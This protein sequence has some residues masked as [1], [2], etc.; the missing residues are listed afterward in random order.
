MRLLWFGLLVWPAAG[1]PAF[2][3]AVLLSEET[4]QSL[5][6]HESDLLSLMDQASQARDA[7]Q[8]ARHLQVISESLTGVFL[9][10]MSKEVTDRFL[11]HMKT[12]VDALQ[13]SIPDRLAASQKHLDHVLSLFYKCDAERVTKLAFADRHEN[14]TARKARSHILCR[15]E[16]AT[17]KLAADTCEKANAELSRSLQEDPTCQNWPA[18]K[19][20]T[21][22]SAACKEPTEKETYEEYLERMRSEFDSQLLLFRQLKHVCSPREN[23]IVSCDED[24]IAYI[25]KLQLCNA[26][27]QQLE[28]ESCRHA[29]E[30]RQAWNSYAGCF[31]DAHRRYQNEAAQAQQLQGAQLKEFQATKK[32]ECMLG[33]FRSTQPKEVLRKCE[34]EVMNAKLP[35]DLQISILCP[36]AYKFPAESLPTYPGSKE[37]GEQKY[38]NVP[39]EA[40]VIQSIHCPVEAVNMSQ[41]EPPS[42]C[43]K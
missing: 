42:G 1:A 30:I 23:A 13:S 14:E 19:A 38:A 28:K 6:A 21:A 9:K 26:L 4:L 11:H 16:E 40:P 37:Y 29:I 3:S 36:P 12:Q 17:A 15:R 31:M 27:Q 35:A 20:L 22:E 18:L 33:G 7:L 43:V 5:S 41:V 34:E 39:H 25:Q 8:E 24:K 32:I 10:N 2:R